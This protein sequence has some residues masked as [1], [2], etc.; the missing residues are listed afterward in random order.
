MPEWKLCGVNLSVG[1]Y[2]EHTYTEMF[3]VNAFWN[4]YDQLTLLLQ[5]DSFPTFE[6]TSQPLRFTS[7]YN[8]M[9]EEEVCCKCK[10]F[11]YSA[12]A[13]PVKGADGLTKIYCGDCIASGV[14]WCATCCEPYEITEENINRPNKCDDCWD[15][16]VM[17]GIKC[18]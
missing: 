8:L 18:N 15:L 2:D 10:Q 16:E 14:D 12:E 6:Y 5:Q 7:L 4:T 11:C 17:H 9:D 3:D 13:F 1:Y